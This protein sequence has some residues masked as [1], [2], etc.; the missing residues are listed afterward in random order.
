MVA[1]YRLP[2]RGRILSAAREVLKRHGEVSSLSEMHFLVLNRLKKE[3]P[4]YRLSKSRLL[5]LIALS[6]RIGVKVEKRRTD[7]EPEHCPLCGGELKDLP[8]IN[9][10]GER[11][12]LGKKCSG[13]GYRIER[14]NLEPRRYRF[15]L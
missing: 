6:H 4:K 5:K 3:N 13:C 2:E 8:G 9:L 15:Y 11:I 14:P 1:G 12:K 7:R 10:F